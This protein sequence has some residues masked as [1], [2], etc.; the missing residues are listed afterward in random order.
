M[1]RKEELS[2]IQWTIIEPLIPKPPSRE[3]RKGRPRRSD[4]EV[5]NGILWILRSGAR[6]YDLPERFP[7][8]QTCRGSRNGC[9]L[10]YSDVSWRLLPL[11]YE[12]VASS[13]S[14]NA[15]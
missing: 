3:D 14:A 1:A 11:T 8:Y 2:D 4:R 13:I 7:P 12:T 9:A 10:E 15:L 6:W 5:L